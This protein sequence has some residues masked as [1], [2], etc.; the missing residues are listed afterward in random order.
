M[1]IFV[2]LREIIYNKNDLQ[3]HLQCTLLNLRLKHNERDVSNNIFRSKKNV[4]N[5]SFSE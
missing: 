2:Y 4:F 5:D 1:A 3:T